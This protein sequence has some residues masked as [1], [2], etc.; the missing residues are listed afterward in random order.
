MEEWHWFPGCRV[1]VVLPAVPW[2]TCLAFSSPDLITTV[3]DVL[4]ETQKDFVI[5]L[6]T[7][8]WESQSLSKNQICRRVTFPKGL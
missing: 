6:L 8:D 7:E 3:P 1:L 4:G 2:K 5:L